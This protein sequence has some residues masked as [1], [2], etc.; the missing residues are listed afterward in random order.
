MTHI[1]RYETFRAASASPTRFAIIQAGHTYAL[2]ACY[3]TMQKALSV[4][5]KAARNNTACGWLVVDRD[6]GLIHQITPKSL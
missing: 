2:Y 5:G 6:L 1:D 3:G 4:A